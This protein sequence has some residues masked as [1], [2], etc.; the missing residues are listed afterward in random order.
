MDVDFNKRYKGAL[1][2]RRG[3]AT[4]ERRA[5]MEGAEA[6]KEAL[7]ERPSLTLATYS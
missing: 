5:S 6:P 3:L 2:A 7:M 1:E 4:A